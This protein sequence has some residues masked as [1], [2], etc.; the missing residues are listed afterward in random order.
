MESCER[1]LELVATGTAPYDAARRVEG[2][3]KRSAGEDNDP[4][5]LE[6]HESSSRFRR[7]A[8]RGMSDYATEEERVFAHA[9]AEALE[10]YDEITDDRIEA[11]YAERAFDPEKGSN[12]SSNRLLHNLAI[13][14]SRRKNSRLTMFRPLLEARTK[15]IHEGAVGHYPMLDVSKLSDDELEQLQGLME[16]A[17]SA[18]VS[19]PAPA[20]QQ[21]LPAGV[22][23]VIDQGA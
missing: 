21:A 9:Y 8:Q 7:M 11:Q 5:I 14:R 23:S 20:R 2:P 15:H 16:K 4:E 6:S 22:P 18:Q 13:S 1:F 17:A 3:V 19:P 10:M 12:G